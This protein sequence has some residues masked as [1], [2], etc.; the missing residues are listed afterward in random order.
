MIM[1]WLIKSTNEFRVETLA[2]VDEF[3]A[4]LYA[5][6]NSLGATVSSFNVNL[7]EVK[8]KGEIIEEYYQVKYTLVFNELKAPENAFFSVEYPMGNVSTQE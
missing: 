7:K 4:N 6:A 1:N 8:S 5:T 3:K 2:G